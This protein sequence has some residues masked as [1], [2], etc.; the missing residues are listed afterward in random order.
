LDSDLVMIYISLSM[1]VILRWL[2]RDC[3]WNV[4]FMW[5]I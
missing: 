3:E 4:Y 1:R 5:R 2:A